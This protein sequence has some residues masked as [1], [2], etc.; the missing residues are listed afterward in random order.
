MKFGRC[1]FNILFGVQLV[2]AAWKQPVMFASTCNPFPV[3]N[4]GVEVSN[5][6][7]RKRCFAGCGTSGIDP[8]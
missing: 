2:S 7:E 1:D 5:C 8:P 3:V 6:G 4:I